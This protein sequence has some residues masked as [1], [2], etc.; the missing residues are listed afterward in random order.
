MFAYIYRCYK[1]AFSA[2]IFSSNLKQP[3][4]LRT[5]GMQLFKHTFEFFLL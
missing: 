2:G 5:E 1:L 4:S 3:M